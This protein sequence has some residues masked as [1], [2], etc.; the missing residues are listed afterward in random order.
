LL[1]VISAWAHLDG[2][3]YDAA[4]TRLQ[5]AEVWLDTTAESREPAEA[6]TSERDGAEMVVVDEAQFPSL[7]ASIAN[8]RAYRAQALGEQAS[9]PGHEHPSCV[10]QAR[11]KKAQ[12]D[13]DGALDLLDEAERLCVWLPRCT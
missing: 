7:P 10:T 11:L 4:E 5:Q 3:E 12:G 8:A 13:L 9:A 1:S 2:G 6:L